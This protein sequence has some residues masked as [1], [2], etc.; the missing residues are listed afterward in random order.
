MVTPENLISATSDTMAKRKELSSDIKTRIIDKHKAGNS[1]NKIS[2]QLH[3]PK[4]TIQSVIKKYKEFGSPANM[5]RAGRPR[6]ISHRMPRKIVRMATINPQVTRRSMQK[7]L[8]DVCLNTVSNTL[9]EAK[10]HGQRPRKTPLLNK[11]HLRE[12]LKYAND[13][14]YKSKEFWKSVL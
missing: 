14:V 3:V 12:R 9:H 11:N 1:Y 4:S 13:H 2:E 10:L 5:P 6:K 7:Q 8:S